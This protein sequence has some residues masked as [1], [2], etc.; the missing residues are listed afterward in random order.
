MRIDELTEG[1]EVNVWV[2]TKCEVVK[3]VETRR[4]GGPDGTGSHQVRSHVQVRDV[5]TGRKITIPIQDARPWAQS[6]RRHMGV[7]GTPVHECG[8]KLSTGRM[9]RCET[10]EGLRKR[11]HELLGL[12][13]AR[14][15]GQA[16]EAILRLFREMA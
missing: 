5:R 12:A 11:L 1:L 15:D 7:A 8:G 9:C 3:V 2:P 16:E 14:F 13:R 10:V 4:P 6:V